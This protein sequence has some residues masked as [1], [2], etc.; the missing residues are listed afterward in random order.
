MYKYSQCYDILVRFTLLSTSWL[1]K[2]TGYFYVNGGS[3]W[4]FKWWTE[5]TNFRTL[6]LHV[7][8]Y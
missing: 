2:M 5:L 7:T 4:Q 3:S 8:K 1:M 6:L